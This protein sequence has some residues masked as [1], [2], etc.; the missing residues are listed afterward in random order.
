MSPHRRVRH[1]LCRT[2]QESPPIFGLT[3]YEEFVSD[4]L[5]LDIQ[6]EFARAN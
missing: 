4:E 1:G 2:F 3:A 5:N 6:I